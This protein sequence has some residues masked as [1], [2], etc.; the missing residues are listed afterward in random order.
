MNS[1][2]MPILIDE[3]S[4]QHQR[5]LFFKTLPKS[6][7]AFLK[8]SIKSVRVIKIVSDDLETLN[9]AAR[10][11]EDWKANPTYFDSKNSSLNT[12]FIDNQSD[13]KP[14]MPVS[15]YKPLMPG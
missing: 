5:T 9:E 7:S 11:L 2:S 10:D 13:N 14:N 3:P 1:I 6:C 12:T 15:D 4:T 8:D